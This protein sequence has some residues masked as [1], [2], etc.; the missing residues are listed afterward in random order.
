MNVYGINRKTKR[1]FI[2]FKTRKKMIVF[3]K[4]KGA[5]VVRLSLFTLSIIFTL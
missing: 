2:D 4:Q 3:I 1:A 5:G